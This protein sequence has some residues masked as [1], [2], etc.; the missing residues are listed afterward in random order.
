MS[1]TWLEEKR[2]KKVREF[3]PGGYGWEMQVGKEK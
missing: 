1:K 3:L 2:W